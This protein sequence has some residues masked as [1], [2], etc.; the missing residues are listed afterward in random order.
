MMKKQIDLS[1]LKIDRFYSDVFC[2]NGYRASASIK[3]KVLDWIE[4]SS[5]FDGEIDVAVTIYEHSGNK[6]VPKSYEAE[7]LMRHDFSKDIILET[8]EWLW[9]YIRMNPDWEEEEV[10]YIETIIYVLRG[11]TNG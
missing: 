4:F 1:K 6:L 3:Y 8:I 11:I 2:T 10:E 7:G 5:L 9:E